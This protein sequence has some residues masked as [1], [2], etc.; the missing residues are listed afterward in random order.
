MSVY[1]TQ[2]SLIKMEANIKLKREIGLFSASSLIISTMI[3]SGIFISPTPILQYSG[4]FGLCLI[5]W[6]VTG[7]ASLLGNVLLIY[8]LAEK[9]NFNMNKALLKLQV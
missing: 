6:V 2:N 3:G 5:M 7:F 1:L 4:S 8:I 9:I